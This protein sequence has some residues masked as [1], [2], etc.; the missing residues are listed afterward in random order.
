[1]SSMKN[2]KPVETVREF[3]ER[4]KKLPQDMPIGTCF[5]PFSKIEIKESTWVHNNYPYDG[6]DTKFINLE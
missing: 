5:D 4:L 3:I 2:A 6:P 1:M